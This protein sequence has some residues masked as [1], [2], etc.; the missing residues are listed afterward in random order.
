MTILLKD[1]DKVDAWSGGGILGAGA[2]TVYV[3]RAEEGTSSGGHPQIELEFRSAQG[4]GS[5]RDWLV[6]IESTAGKV[7]SLLDAT[8]IEPQA[9]EWQFEP[10]M[11]VGRKLDIRVSEEPDRNDPSKTRSRVQEYATAGA[12]ATDVPADTSGL[13]AGN[14][15]AKDDNLPF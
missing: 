2:H 14:G 1:M 5:I 9:G 6:C 7:R 10:R 12:L 8:G 3:D 15:A 11:L 4:A 13:P